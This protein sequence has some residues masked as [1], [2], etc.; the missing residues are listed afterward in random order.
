MKDR[1]TFDKNKQGTK[2]MMSCS[3]ASWLSVKPF[4]LNKFPNKSIYEK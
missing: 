3:E 4:I 1:V 2:D